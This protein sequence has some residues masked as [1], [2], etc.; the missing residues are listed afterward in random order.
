MGPRFPHASAPLCNVVV[1]RAGARIVSVGYNEE[2]LIGLLVYP[3]AYIVTFLN[4]FLSDFEAQSSFRGHGPGMLPGGCW[5]TRAMIWIQTRLCNHRH[6]I[7]DHS[8][9]FIL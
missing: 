9:C 1:A 8:C 4:F 7:N 3:L 5:I 6:S 2:A